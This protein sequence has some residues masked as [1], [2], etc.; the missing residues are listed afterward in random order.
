MRR[1]PF[2]LDTGFLVALVNA[3]DP[4]HE[5]CDRVWNE[6]SGP[7]LSTEGV[8]VETAH[9]VRKHRGGF[10]T[11]WGLLRSVGTLIAAPT[12]PRVDRAVELMEC[13]A[14]I[15]MD[16]VDGTLVAVAEE[17]GVLDVLTLDRRGF[18]AYRCGGKRFRVHPS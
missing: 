12:N 2:L 16:L 1:G 6:I 4:D 5:A 9:L 10:A 8:L 3:A 11:V 14:D 15:P 17:S 18:G 7:F 13:Y